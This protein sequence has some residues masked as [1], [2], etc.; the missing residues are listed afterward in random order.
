MY[1]QNAGLMSPHSRQ[2]LRENGVIASASQCFLIYQCQQFYFESAYY[3]DFLTG[4]D[5][6]F[7]LI[8]GGNKAGVCGTRLDACYMPDQNTDC[9]CRKIRLRWSI[10]LPIAEQSCYVSVL[11]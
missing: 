5:S 7:S 6:G 1:H 9:F 2:R 4:Q 3:L 8:V 11:Q 10:Q